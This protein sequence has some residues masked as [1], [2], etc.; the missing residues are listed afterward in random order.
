VQ[1]FQNIQSDGLRNSAHLGRHVGQKT[2]FL[3]W[4]SPCGRGLD[5]S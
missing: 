2:D 4:F 3:H 5:P 1:R